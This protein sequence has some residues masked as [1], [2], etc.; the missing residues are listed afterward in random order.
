MSRL[1][2]VLGA[3][4]V[5]VLLLAGCGTTT[6]G[7]TVK[8]TEA[9]AGKRV[10]LAPGD[11]LEI[12]LEGNPST[13]YNWEVESVDNAIL[14]QVGEPQFEADSSAVGSPGVITLAFQALASG[15]TNLKLIYHR[16]FEPEV[17]PL[18]TYEVSVVV[19]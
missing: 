12:A 18:E 14:K 4:S 7:Q 13:G 10:E 9:D 3:V 11:T 5:A 16:S 15:Q 19:K 6:G 8:L 2:F 17:A 1:I